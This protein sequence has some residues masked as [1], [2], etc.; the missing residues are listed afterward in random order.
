MHSH[1]TPLPQIGGVACE[2]NQRADQIID[3]AAVIILITLFASGEA[4]LSTF[5]YPLPMMFGGGGT[6]G[7]RQYIDECI[8]SY[9]HSDR[10]VCIG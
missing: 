9:P 5:S 4:F 8:I 6:G 10:Q 7:G 2:T 1:Q 3:E